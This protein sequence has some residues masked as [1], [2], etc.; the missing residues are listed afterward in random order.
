R[1]EMLALVIP[2][3]HGDD[4]CR[5][6]RLF[7]ARE[8][9]SEGIDRYGVVQIDS[10]ILPTEK[11]AYSFVAAALV[12]DE[13]HRI[14]PQRLSD[15]VVYQDGL[16]GPGGARNHG[17]RRLVVEEIKGDGRPPPAEI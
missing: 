10:E 6:Q 15:H 9:S 14:E 12:D 2:R 13:D 17:M 11:L 5:Q 1:I 7:F 4:Q 3:R 16:S 8:F